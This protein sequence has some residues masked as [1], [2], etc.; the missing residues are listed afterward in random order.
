MNWRSPRYLLLSSAIIVLVVILAIV[1]IFVFHAGHA[2]IS[3][4]H[5]TAQKTVVPA[6][7]R[8]VVQTYNQAVIKQDWATVYVNTS[9]I[10]TGNNTQEQFAQAMAVQE[11]NEGKVVS[12]TVT[13]PPQVFTNSGGSPYFTIQE[14]EVIVQNGITQ[15]QSLLSVYL[16]EDG[17]WKYWFSKKA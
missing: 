15:T 12:I 3:T 11:Q 16:L 6:N 2:Q 13:S 17:T 4:Q 10:V 1:A 7:E 14:Q 5:P 9:N 8:R